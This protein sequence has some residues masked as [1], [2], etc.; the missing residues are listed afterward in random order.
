MARHGVE[1]RVFDLRQ[2]GVPCEA[3]RPGNEQSGPV[4]RANGRFKVDRERT[5]KR[6][7]NAP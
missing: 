6:A 2:M 5:Q 1:G 7:Y 4:A 3:S